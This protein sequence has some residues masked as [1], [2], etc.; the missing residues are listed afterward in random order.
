MNSFPA[1]STFSVSMGVSIGGI[2]GIFNFEIF[3]DL[4]IFKIN[5]K[6]ALD[7]SPNFSKV[8]LF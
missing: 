1:S 6:I 8:V 2:K 4:A 7:V 3:V 5:L